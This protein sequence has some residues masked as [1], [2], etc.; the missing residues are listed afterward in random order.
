MCLIATKKHLWPVSLHLREMATEGN[1]RACVCVC[2]CVAGGVWVG[3][4]GAAVTSSATATPH[5]GEVNS[6]GI[7]KCCAISTVMT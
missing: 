5:H 7:P 1:E 2:V 4:E 3:S 6:A